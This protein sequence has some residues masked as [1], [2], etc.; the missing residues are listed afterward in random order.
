[1]DLH[2]K[3]R[4][5]DSEK[6]N[7]ISRK[8]KRKDFLNNTSLKKAFCRIAAERESASNEPPKKRRRRHGGVYADDMSLVTPEDAATRPGWKVTPL[9]RTMRP[10]K[11]RP[12]HPLPPT[13]DEVKGVRKSE[14]H[15]DDAVNVNL[16][17]K[18]KKVKDPDTRARRKAIDMTK[19]GSEYLKGMF[20][21]LEVQ[22]GG[23]EVVVDMSVVVDSGNESSENGEEE[24]KA[25]PSVSTSNAQSKARSP[26]PTSIPIEPFPAMVT[27]TSQAPRPVRAA[28]SVP[29][30]NTNLALETSQSLNLL[31]SLFGGKDEDEDWV[32]RESVGSDIDEDEL[33]KGDKMLVDADEEGLNDFEVVPISKSMESISIQNDDRKNEEVE[34]IAHPK[35][36]QNIVPQPKKPTQQTKLKDLFAPRDE[37]GM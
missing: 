32:G 30:N 35:A 6:P 26:P 16:K 29:E 27:S 24:E 5:Y 17:K 23:K 19:W 4:N 20:L 25:R 18:K 15:A 21:D 1:M 9:G 36:T 14:K 8:G 22:Q 37:E 3:A 7:L 11:M 31:A 33:V 10:I 28:S 2:G 12:T 13:Q 34:K